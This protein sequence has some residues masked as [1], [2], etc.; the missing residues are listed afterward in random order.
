MHDFP[1]ESR[2]KHI[3]QWR[4]VKGDTRNAIYHASI[5][6]NVIFLQRES[7]LGIIYSFFP[8]ARLNRIA[9]SN[10]HLYIYV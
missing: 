7:S 4:D 9:T 1:K 2:A 10:V 5:G 3:Q 8:S 6:R